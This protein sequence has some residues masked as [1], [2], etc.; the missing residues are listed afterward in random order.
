MASGIMPF[1]KKSAL[2]KSKHSKAG[3]P[4]MT[5]ER[6]FEARGVGYF[7]LVFAVCCL[8]SGLFGQAQT[9]AAASSAGVAAAVSGDSST[10]REAN[11]PPDKHAP[12]AHDPTPPPPSAPAPAA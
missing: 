12:P 3:E 7:L 10:G 9:P 8:S 2:R 11:P 6:G 5:D 4:P 1:P